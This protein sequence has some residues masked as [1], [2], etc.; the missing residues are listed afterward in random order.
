MYV[1]QLAIVNPL[2]EKALEACATQGAALDTGAGATIV[3]VDPVRLARAEVVEIVPELAS[4]LD[5]SLVQE[6]DRATLA[7]MRTDD[8]G[9]NRVSQPPSGCAPR[10]FQ[11]GETWRLENNHFKF[12]ITAGRITSLYDVLD[13]RE[14]IL[15]GSSVKTGGLMTYDDFPLAYDAWDAEIYHLDCSHE[16]EFGDLSVVANGPLRASLQAVARF[17]NSTVTMTVSSNLRP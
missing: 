5:G 15:A 9:V 10:A 1:K 6:Q 11:D 14:L 17:G 2:I 8:D 4:S 13:D 16:I 3:G 7:L 12:A